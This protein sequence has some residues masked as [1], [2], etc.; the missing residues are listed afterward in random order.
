MTQQL[1][2]TSEPVHDRLDLATADLEPDSRLALRSAFDT[3]FADA[4]RW[5][6]AAKAIVVTS[7]TD[8][9]GMKAARE[10]RLALRE[11]R[12]N[13]DK[14][15]ERLK[16]DSL[17]RGKA[18]DGIFAVLK[19][20]VAP[21]EEHLQELED[22]G[23]RAVEARKSALREA[24][25][26]TLSALG[27]DPTAYVDLGA[28]AD[29]TWATTLLNAQAARDAKLEA[30]RRETAI[31]VEA[32]RITTENREKARLAGIQAE[33]ERIERERAAK[34][35]NERLCKEA[36]E[37]EAAA[38]AERDRLD[39]EHAAERAAA[40]AEADASKEAAR[41]EL[42]AIQTAHREEAAKRA[43][44]ASAEHDRIETIA[45]TERA[46][47]DR[48][49]AELAATKAAQARGVAA[50][51]RDMAEIQAR[52]KAAATAPDKEKLAALAAYI[53]AAPIPTLTTEHGQTAQ[54]QI[55]E[56]IERWAIWIEKT[57]QAL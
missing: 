7:E 46:E 41:V 6:A 45:R 10:T 33:A 3:M 39:Q 21:I 36:I 16:A 12:C 25:K 44:V 24:R 50:Q 34:A 51:E 32:E 52:R 53:R 38:K 5:T 9:R 8:T 26:E 17:R 1:A 11:I 47:R 15:R 31:R 2:L 35:E 18:I 48:L 49:A 20:L 22:T 23:K 56:Q 19:A 40:K 57:G 28:M 54:R 43:A 13:A 14:A 29:E 27:S 55:K 4:D 37:R 30:E 42:E